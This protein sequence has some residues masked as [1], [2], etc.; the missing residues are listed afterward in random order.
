[1][2]KIGYFI[3]LCFFECSVFTIVSAESEIIRTENY[4]YRLS[5]K[6]LSF[7]PT[8]GKSQLTLPT[9]IEGYPVVGISEELLSRIPNFVLFLFHTQLHR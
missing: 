8:R 9:E 6:E 5:T 7:I 4:G 1:M 2:K 3:L